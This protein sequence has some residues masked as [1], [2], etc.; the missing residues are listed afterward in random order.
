M[1]TEGSWTRLITPEG[2]RPRHGRRSGG[3]AT[4]AISRVTSKMS[5][6]SGFRSGSR[7][8]EQGIVPALIFCLGERAVLLWKAE[9]GGKPVDDHEAFGVDDGRDGPHRAGATV[10]QISLARSCGTR[11]APVSVPEA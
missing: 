1:T 3:R 4:G 11:G 6:R 7:K 9:H 2:H 8:S 10:V 5:V